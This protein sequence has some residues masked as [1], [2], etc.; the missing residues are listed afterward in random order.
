MPFEQQVAIIYAAING[1]A[2]GIAVEKMKEYEEAFH[3]YF[4]TAGTKTLDLIREK[5]ELAADVEAAL[6]KT[7]E[8]FN[9]TLQ[10]K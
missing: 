1:F 8:S 5:K 3:Q 10:P 9:S 7:I 6:K 4:T 2:D